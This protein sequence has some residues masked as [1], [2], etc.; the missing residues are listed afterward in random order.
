MLIFGLI[1][2]LVL[3]ITGAPIFVALGLGSTI[4]LIYAA[5]LPMVEIAHVLFQSI[6]SFTLLAAPLFILAGDLMIHGASAKALTD[7][8]GSLVKHLRG[9]LLAATVASCAFFAALSGSATATIVAIGTIMIPE[10]QKNGYDQRIS[11]GVVAVSGTL[12]NL[13]PPS[14]VFITYA[15]LAGVPTAKCF[16]AGM[17][18]GVLTAAMLIGTGI[19]ICRRKQFILPPASSWGERKS[20]FVRAI[21]ALIMPVIILGGIYCGIFTPTEAAGVACVY[22]L[23]IGWVIYR[24]SSVVDIWAALEQTARTTGMLYML[25][26]SASLLNFVLTFVGIPQAI[27]MFVVSLNLNS[28][29]FLV[30][31]SLV[32]VMLGFVMEPISLMFV[33]VPIM[34]P[35]CATLGINMVHFGVVVC[36]SILVGMITPPMAI[37]LYITSKVS[38]VPPQ[39]VIRGAIPFLITMCGALIIVI[40]WPGLSLWLPSVIG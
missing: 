23:F 6:N 17:M 28:L 13:I 32:Y 20:S 16:A 39:E 22:A 37:Q 26:A 5:G 11:T 36:I 25:I 34:M 27:N 7:F 15:V 24:E 2:C 3:F 29:S 38:G 4:A 14:I 12:G 30:I 9:G 18:P 35:S 33:A 1:L 19:F 40:L 21:P 10:M 31:F 8:M